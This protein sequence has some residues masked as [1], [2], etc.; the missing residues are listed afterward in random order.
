MKL[1]IRD[2]VKTFGGKKALDG[3]SATFETGGFYGLF[4]RNGAGKSTLFRC[5]ADLIAPDSGSVTLDGTDVKELKADRRRLIAIASEDNLFPS[6]TRVEKLALW[7]SEARG[8]DVSPLIGDLNLFGVA[9]GKKWEKLSTGE[10]TMLKNALA[11]NSGAA[12]VFLDEPALGLDAVNR[13]NLY[14]RLMETVSKSR[15]YVLSSHLIDEAAPLCTH[16]TFIS[17]GRNALDETSEFIAENAWTATGT[18]AELDSMTGDFTIVRSGEKLGVQ[19]R[20]VL[21][22]IADNAGCSLERTDL[23]RL[24]I[25]FNK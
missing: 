8:V 17:D 16:V 23:E 18:A 20:C 9:L 25:E 24:F 2:L 5:A 11:I 1:E 13:D 15:A 21:G 3:F 6:D 19:Y 7:Y 4:G 14:R 10:R 12:F 22:M